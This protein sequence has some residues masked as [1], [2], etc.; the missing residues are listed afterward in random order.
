MLSLQS[1]NSKLSVR[2]ETEQTDEA[3]ERILINGERNGFKT[4]G[5][6]RECEDMSYL[7]FKK[8]LINVLYKSAKATNNILAVLLEEHLQLFGYD[9]ALNV[10]HM[11]LNYIP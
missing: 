11:H 9:V 6:R 10:Y 8:N 4:L 1:I 2:Q 7:S 3:T 5:W